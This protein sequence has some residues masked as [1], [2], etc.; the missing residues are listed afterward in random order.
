MGLNYLEKRQQT[1][2][3]LKEFLL[4][5]SEYSVNKNDVVGCQALIYSN[6]QEQPLFL[7]A[8]SDG[9]IKDKK[10]VVKNFK[11]RE[12]VGLTLLFMPGVIEAINEELVLLLKKV[13]T[14]FKIE[15]KNVIIVITTEFTTI[16]DIQISVFDKKEKRGNI[17]MVYIFPEPKEEEE[18]E[19]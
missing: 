4:L 14:D 6:E 7:G 16:Q 18:I 15:Q 9:F 3:I 17:D 1:Q 5:V 19:K 13:A 8:D 12:I 10:G 11:L 2:D